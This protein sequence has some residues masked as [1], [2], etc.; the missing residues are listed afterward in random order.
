MKKF[1]KL[2]TSM[3]VTMLLCLACGEKDVMD[4]VGKMY[5]NGIER[6][7]QAEAIGD[8]QNIYDEV[9]Q[10]VNSFVSGHWKEFSELDSA[11][12]SLKLAEEAFLKV[13]CSKVKASGHGITT[14]KGYTLLDENG[15]LLVTDPGN[16]LNFTGYIYNPVPDR[17]FQ[18]HLTVRT[19][20]GEYLYNE[21]DA[22]RYYDHYVSH[23]FFASKIALSLLYSY[24]YLSLHVEKSVKEYVQNNLFDIVSHLPLDTSYPTDVAEEVN[25][26]YDSYRDEAATLHL[27][28][29]EHGRS[30]YGYF[31]DSNPNSLRYFDVGRDRNNGGKLIF[32]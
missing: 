26:V 3:L 12:D 30:R 13:C 2:S 5:E 18:D 20:H 11:S 27:I 7:L 8:V 21:A 24:S 6:V 25:K 10:Q 9:T 19:P 23:F 14:E 28:E 29:R 31:E 4:A 15:N 17:F 16:P 1:L 32:D 22:E